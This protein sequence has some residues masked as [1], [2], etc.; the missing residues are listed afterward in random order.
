M[1]LHAN[2]FIHQCNSQIEICLLYGKKPAPVVWFDHPLIERGFVMGAR[3]FVHFVNGKAPS[4][5]RV[6]LHCGPTLDHSGNSRREKEKNVS[7]V[8]C[9]SRRWISP[10]HWINACLAMAKN[11]IYKV[12]SIVLLTFNLVT[13]FRFN[14]PASLICH[15]VTPFWVFTLITNTLD[16]ISINSGRNTSF[17]C[18]KCM[19]NKRI[20]SK[21]MCF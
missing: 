14:G 4:P 8:D 15:F 19:L 17:H 1:S 2:P 18:N 20:D 16:S 12:L 10:I 9:Y 21:P 5:L 3:V 11:I 13:V 6:F 7:G